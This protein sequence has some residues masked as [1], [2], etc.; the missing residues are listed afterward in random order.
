MNKQ[1]IVILSRTLPFHSIGGMQAIAW[2]L[3]RQFV[4]D[5]VR[6]TIITTRIPGKPVSFKLEGVEV[7]ALK[8]AP[9][10]RYSL[11]WWRNSREYFERHLMDSVSGILSVSAAAY[12]ILPLKPKLRGVP[13]VFQ[14][15]GTSIGE[16]ASKWRSRKFKAVLS[17]A[18]N[19]I[20]LVKDLLAYPKFD[21][22][23]AVG[24]RVEKDLFRPPNAWVLP[25][26]RVCLIRNGINTDLF[27][28]DEQARIK[29]RSALGWT[30]K[31]RVIV[32]ASRLH[33]QKGIDLG[34]RGFAKYVQKDPNA[35]YMIVGD[36]PERENLKSLVR[37]LGLEDKISFIGAVQREQLPGYL[38]AGD[39]FLFTTTCV[40][41]LP[42]NVLEALA[43]G[44]P[45]VVS[46]HLQSVLEISQYV[47]GVVPHD[48]VAVA[49]AIERAL[50]DSR[51]P[52][53]LLP[54]EYTLEY[55]VKKY[56]NILGIK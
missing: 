56:L 45:A 20:W 26:E 22:V 7:V 54:E 9:P 37:S 33:R 43:T 19:L 42:L 2:D 31:E 44:L 25:R 10:E 49:G 52:V 14:A 1:H 11:T 5:G 46:Q 24:D 55:C 51:K 50:D 34:I 53:S 36:G 48:V 27:F 3:A 12:G 15:H 18:R 39:V 28:P 6:V 17:S 16:I 13:F 30:E 21:M 32:S 47:K 38:R 8:N 29:M 23:V 35:R 40:E 41:G 4:K